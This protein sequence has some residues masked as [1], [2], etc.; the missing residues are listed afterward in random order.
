MQRFAAIKTELH[1]MRR[2]IQC[3]APEDLFH[4]GNFLFPAT[5]S[6]AQRPRYTESATPCPLYPPRTIIFLLFKWCLNTGVISSAIKIG[7]PH[8]FVNCTFSS[9]GCKECTRDSN[10]RISPAA[11]PPEMFRLNSSLQCSTCTRPLPNITWLP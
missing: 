11:S 6:A 8:R 5:T 3:L 7:P 1:V 9:A 2:S 4:D 10:S